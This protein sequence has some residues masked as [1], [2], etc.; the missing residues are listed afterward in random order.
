MADG[1]KITELFKKRSEQGERELDRKYGKLCRG[2]SYSVVN[3][4]QDAGRGRH[5]PASV[6]L[7]AKPCQG[8]GIERAAVPLSWLLVSA[9]GERKD[10]QP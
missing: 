4:L 3:S 8:S 7:P 5:S 2:L 1:G 9:A 6:R 10:I